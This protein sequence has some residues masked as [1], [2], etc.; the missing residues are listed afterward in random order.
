MIVVTNGSLIITELR[1]S[2]LSKPQNGEKYSTASYFRRLC[3][4]LIFAIQ[5]LLQ[6]YTDLGE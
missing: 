4:V 2:S 6:I 3:M 5:L 1:A